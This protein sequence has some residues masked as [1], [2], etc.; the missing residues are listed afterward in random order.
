M[1]VVCLGRSSR[2]LPCIML[3]V[4]TMCLIVMIT[5]VPYMYN[6]ASVNII[7]KSEN[8]RKRL[9][10]VILIGAGKSGTSAVINFMGRH[11]SVVSKDGETN[12]F[13]LYYDKGYEWYRQQM[14]VSSPDQ[15]TLVKTAG[16]L[17]KTHV[18]DRIYAFNSSIK[19]MVV[20]REP[21]VRSLSCY[22]QYVSE[23][24]KN[25]E[26]PQ[27]FE[28]MVLIKETGQVN[29][30]SPPINTGC[31][32][33]PLYAWLHRFKRDQLHILDGEILI[34]NPYLE[35]NKAEQFLGLPRYFTQDMFHYNKQKGFYCP[36]D[37]D[38]NEKCMTESKGREHI[39]ISSELREK[40][41][42]H[43]KKCNENLT[44]LTGQSFSWMS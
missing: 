4:M 33:D 23:L 39:T 16:Y 24:S 9:P 15:L 6:Q 43:F 32:S 7:S 18:P 42:K 26:K 28:E 29:P 3:S 30:K 27:T 31:Y 13:H 44:A 12:Y 35:L 2:R 25:G 34:Q 37:A 10:S 1:D 21:V 5:T 40:I 38:G 17:Y 14:P 8:L 41:S 20:I 11:P 19:L 36:L 22:A